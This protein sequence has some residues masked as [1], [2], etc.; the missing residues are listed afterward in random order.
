MFE[1]HYRNV[2]QGLQDLIKLSANFSNLQMV[3]AYLFQLNDELLSLDLENFQSEH[4]FVVAHKGVKS[5][6][7]LLQ[8]YRSFLFE[9]N[10]EI[11]T[12]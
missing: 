10:P 5:K 12:Q 3:D 8:E 7:E 9:I 4:K 1:A 6:I 2:S 11:N